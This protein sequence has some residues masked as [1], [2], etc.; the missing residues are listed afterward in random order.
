MQSDISGTVMP[1]L[2]ILLDAGE[3]ILAE[4]GEFA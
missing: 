2:R 3:S 1:V 4:T